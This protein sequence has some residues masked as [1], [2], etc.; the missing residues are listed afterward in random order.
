MEVRRAVAPIPQGAFVL[1]NTE[2]QP[3][4]ALL[5]SVAFSTDGLGLTPGNPLNLIQASEAAEEAALLQRSEAPKS[6]SPPVPRKEPDIRW[7]EP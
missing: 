6:S 3:S 2:A 1:R 4:Q 7:L 5:G